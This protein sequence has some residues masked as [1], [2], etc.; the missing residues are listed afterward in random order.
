MNLFFTC[1]LE[2]ALTDADI[3]FIAVSTPTKSK[4]LGSNQSLD[5]SFVENAARII[6]AFYSERKPQEEKIIIVVEKST[7]PVYTSKLIQSIL[8]EGESKG[9]QKFSVISNPEFL[10][11]GS[12]VHD[13]LH[14]DRV[15]IGGTEE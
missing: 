1:N 8:Q 10:A 11:E 6:S 9:E 4:G 2:E 15:I 3:I 5:L 12:A 13:L 7:V 14:P